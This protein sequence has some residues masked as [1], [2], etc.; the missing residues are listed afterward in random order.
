MSEHDKIRERLALAAAGA[1]DDDAER[2][3]LRGHLSECV[4]CAQE[5]EGWNALAGGLRR[6]PTPRPSAAL[7]ERTRARMVAR[8]AAES[9]RRWNVSMLVFAVLFAWTLTLAG[10]PIARLLTSGAAA[11]LDM[12]FR[13]AWLGYAA[14]TAVGW[15]T[16]G[17]AAV[18]LGLR[19][20]TS[21]RMA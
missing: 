18:I 6:L 19:H 14:Y 1:L 3:R 17:V 16:A 11:W 10:W 15:A 21:R 2:E 7:V 13:Q 8:L 12:S 9:E 5:L 20:R 4:E